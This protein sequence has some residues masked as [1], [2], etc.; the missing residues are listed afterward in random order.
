MSVLSRCSQEARCVLERVAEVIRGLF[1][2]GLAPGLQP[3]LSRKVRSDK[4]WLDLVLENSYCGSMSLY[5]PGWLLPPCP[6]G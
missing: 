6:Q 1:E 3:F 2:W 4:V 5:I